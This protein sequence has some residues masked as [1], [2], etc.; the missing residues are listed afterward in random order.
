MRYTRLLISGS[1]SSAALS[2]ADQKAVPSSRSET[3]TTNWQSRLRCMFLPLRVNQGLHDLMGFIFA[4]RHGS[5]SGNDKPVVAHAHPS[6]PC[7]RAV[8]VQ[9]EVHSPF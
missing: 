3:S 5:E 7:V 2:A 6:A 9:G 1:G 4:A 8:R